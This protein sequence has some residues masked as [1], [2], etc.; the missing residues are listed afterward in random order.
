MDRMIGWVLAGLLVMSGAACTSVLPPESTPAIGPSFNEA[1]KEGYIELAAAEWNEGDWRYLH[2]QD[3]ARAAMRGNL[4]LPDDA[5]VP[6]VPRPLQPELVGQCERLLVF[7]DAGAR[8]LAPGEAAE[9]QV[10]FDCWLSEVKELGQ[11]DTA[12]RDGFAAA[13]AQ[14]EAAVLASLPEVYVVFFELGS[15]AVGAQGLNV[16]TAVAN[17]AELVQPRRIDVVGFADPS[18]PAALNESL[19]LQRAERI[20]ALLER[21]GVAPDA[22]AVQARPPAAGALSGAAARRVEIRLAS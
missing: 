2:F 9:A 4:V 8:E 13:L 14:S 12:C 15:D 20:G 7:L 3:K 21:A 22:I 17:A 6:A 5:T 16:A 1:L 10:S 18:G 19:A 11:L